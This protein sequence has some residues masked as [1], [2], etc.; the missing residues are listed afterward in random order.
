MAL[1]LAI[2]TLFNNARNQIIVSQAMSAV[3]GV[4]LGPG[5][6]IFAALS[7]DAL[8]EYRLA[9]IIFGILIS[10]LLAG[11]FF[12]TRR[13]LAAADRIITAFEKT[14]ES[15]ERIYAIREKSNYAGSYRLR[16]ELVDGAAETLPIGEEDYNALINYLRAKFPAVLKESTPSRES[17]A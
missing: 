11:L 13:K 16:V 17:D 2:S 8:P 15:I 12:E 3:V 1:P 4:L 9:I 6:L 10:L 5:C 14:P 7:T